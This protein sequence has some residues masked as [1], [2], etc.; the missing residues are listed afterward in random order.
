MNFKCNFKIVW[1]GSELNL[2]KS[3]LAC[4]PR[5][6]KVFNFSL[7]T[8]KGTLN[9]DFI[10]NVSVITKAMLGNVIQLFIYIHNLFKR[11]S[12]DNNTKLY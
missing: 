12:N 3:K 10:I 6:K 2:K 4:K 11:C 9:M 7:D 1:S 5:K 8:S